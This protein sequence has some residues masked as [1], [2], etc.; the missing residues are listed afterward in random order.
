MSKPEKILLVEELSTKLADA[1]GV[2]LTDFTGLT[3][4]EAVDFRNKLREK[5]GVEYRVIKNT[6]TNLAIKESDKEGLSE[7]LVGP[8]GI[9]MSFNDAVAPA[10]VLYDFAKDSENIKLKACWLD[11]EIYT[12]EKFEKLA[13]LPSKDELLSKLLSGLQAPMQNLVGVLNASM[14]NLAGALNALKNQ[15]S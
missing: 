8:T 1:K 9:I 7:Y 12:L 3:V 2:Y 10:K 6:I 15:K 5:E 4:S 11:G 13:R 14:Q